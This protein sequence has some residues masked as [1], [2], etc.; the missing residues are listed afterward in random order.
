MSSGKIKGSQG[1]NEFT[2]PILYFNQG[3]D[4]KFFIKKNKTVSFKK[5]FFFWYVSD[6]LNTA[7]VSSSMK[8]TVIGI[9]G[10]YVFFFK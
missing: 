8:S 5:K 2:S 1:F 6:N 4:N 10:F 3:L 7:V 9:H